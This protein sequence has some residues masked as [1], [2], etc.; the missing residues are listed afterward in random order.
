L[1]AA[2]IFK[3]L[4]FSDRRLRLSGDANV[5]LLSAPRLPTNAL[6]PAQHAA[7]RPRSARA[8]A[9]YPHRY[10]VVIAQVCVPPRYA[11]GAHG[12]TRP[13]VA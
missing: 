9:R 2:H 10:S 12:V 6:K 13:T 3:F 4:Y 7:L 8:A 1:A 11:R 5:C